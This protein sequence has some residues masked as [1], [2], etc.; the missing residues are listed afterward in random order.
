MDNILRVFTLSETV[1]LG[2][3]VVQRSIIKGFPLLLVSLPKVT[4]QSFSRF[5]L[6][7]GQRRIEVILFYAGEG[8]KSSSSEKS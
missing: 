2:N 7:S 8:G 5:N 3:G 1:I 6:L 4:L